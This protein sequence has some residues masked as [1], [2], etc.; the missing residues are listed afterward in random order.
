M[1]FIPSRKSARSICCKGC[2]IY[3]VFCPS[4]NASRTL[5]R[6]NSLQHIRRRSSPSL[7][8]TRSRQILNTE[9][10]LRLLC[11]IFSQKRTLGCEPKGAECTVGFVVKPDRAYFSKMHGQVGLIKYVAEVEVGRAFL[12]GRVGRRTQP[13]IIWKNAHLGFTLLE[14]KP[15]GANLH[16][17]TLI[18]TTVQL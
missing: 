3:S 10:T 4:R 6:S 18:C 13:C 17:A 8:R 7:G 1:T 9:T 12:L 2:L 14:T 15:K 11:R 5:S 16:A